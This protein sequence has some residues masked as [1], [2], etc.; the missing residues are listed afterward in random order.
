MDITRDDNGNYDLRG[1]TPFQL[2]IIMDALDEFDEGNI[3]SMHAVMDMADE[4]RKE[5]DK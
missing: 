5:L 1:L 4:I 3:S 2:E